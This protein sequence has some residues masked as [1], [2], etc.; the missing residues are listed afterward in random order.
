LALNAK[1]FITY[2]SIAEL[3]NIAK[4]FD[5]QLVIKFINQKFIEDVDRSPQNS[6][7][8]GLIFY[9]NSTNFQN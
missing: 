1:D 9:L 8:N 2:E 7:K 3:R 6:L 4:S 5:Q